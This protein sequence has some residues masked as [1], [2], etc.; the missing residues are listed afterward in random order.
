[1]KNKRIATT[2]LLI[3][4]AMILSYVETL[5]PV[6]VAVPGMK[7]GLTNLV[8][9]VA[10]VYLD[11]KYAFGINM[12]RILLVAFTFGNMF[13]LMYSLAGGMLSFIIMFLLYKSGKFSYIGISVSGGVAHNIGQ[14]LVA[15]FVLDT[16]SLIYY[17]PVLLI[18]G[19]VAGAIIGILGGEVLKRLPKNLS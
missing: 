7:L 1:M 14:I 19:V 2:A 9:L 8:V 11:G 13:A 3:A 18:S 5:I 15:M 6:F 4:L 10:L 17:L 12:L 16:A